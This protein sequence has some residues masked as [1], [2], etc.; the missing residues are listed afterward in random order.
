MKKCKSEGCKND[1]FSH[2]YCK[3]HQSERTDDKAM[4]LKNVV[5]KTKPI[6]RTTI[7]AKFKAPSGQLECFKSIWSEREHVSELSGDKLMIFDIYNFHHILT[8]QSYPKFLL[9]KDNII[10]LTRREHRLVHA[11]SFEDLIKMDSRWFA[12]QERYQKLKQQYNYEQR[13]MG[14]EER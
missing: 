8:K 2:H 9:N 4:G 7:K 3:W 10:L 1:V 13:E 6:P 12:V 11:H 14:Q 5:S